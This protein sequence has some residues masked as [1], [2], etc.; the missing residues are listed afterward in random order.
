MRLPRPWT[1]KPLRLQPRWQR[2][3]R[4]KRSTLSMRMRSSSRGR[5]RRT[6]FRPT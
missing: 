5:G 2:Q 3:L 6:R 1:Y 4:P